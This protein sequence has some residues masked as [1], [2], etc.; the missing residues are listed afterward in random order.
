MAVGNRYIE[1]E[2]LYQAMLFLI[3]T[4]FYFYTHR[5]FIL[6]NIYHVAQYTLKELQYTLEN[7]NKIV[8]TIFL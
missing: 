2:T 8:K 5:G 6:Q 3:V 1:T 7:K 4:A